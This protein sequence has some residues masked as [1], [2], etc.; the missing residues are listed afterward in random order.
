MPTFSL[1]L[2]Q[3]SLILL[4][5]KYKC[6]LELSKEAILSWILNLVASLVG[7]GGNILIHLKG[8]W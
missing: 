2:M 4:T 7:M 1:I 6:H 8:V 3:K 5:G